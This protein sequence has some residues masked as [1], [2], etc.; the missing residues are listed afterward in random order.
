MP[1]PPIFSFEVRH[2]NVCLHLHESEL[3]S[4]DRIIKSLV[5]SSAT[6]EKLSL[7]LGLCVNG[8]DERSFSILRLMNL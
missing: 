3:Q 2:I 8:A 7:Y 1:L 6:T 4:A 5:C